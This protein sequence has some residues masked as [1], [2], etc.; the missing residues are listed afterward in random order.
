M[1]SLR[2]FML[3]TPE[4]RACIE[5]F[6]AHRNE[7]HVSRSLAK[8]RTQRQAMRQERRLRLA[9]KHDLPIYRQHG[10]SSQESTSTTSTSQCRLRVTWSNGLDPVYF[11]GTRYQCAKLVFLYLVTGQS[12]KNLTE[13]SLND[14]VKRAWF[15]FSSETLQDDTRS[16]SAP[17]TVTESYVQATHP[18]EGTVLADR[19]SVDR[20][21]SQRSMSD[22]AKSDRNL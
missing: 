1:I 3:S 19:L 5:L 2:D 10:N 22:S 12:G 17:K 13:R 4:S 14:S 15:L 18:H 21:S 9:L 20:G 11:S 16:T 6:R 8:I 7:K